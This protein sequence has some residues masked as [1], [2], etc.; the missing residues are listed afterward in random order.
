MNGRKEVSIGSKRFAPGFQTMEV[1]KYLGIRIRE[2]TELQIRHCLFRP[3]ITVGLG[4]TIL[5]FSSSSPLL[6]ASS[7]SQPTCTVSMAA[8]TRKLAEEMAR[9][10]SSCRIDPFRPHIQL[11]TF[12]KSLATH[13]RLT[14]AAVRAAQ[15]LERNEMQKKVTLLPR[16]VLGL[17]QSQLFLVCSNGQNLKT[18]FGSSPLRE[19]C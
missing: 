9:I 1:G 6:Q 13:P 14:P 17:S 8:P 5:V 4:L 7:P 3:Q 18:R 11:Q 19:T 10:A 15:A 2:N 12:L 16:L